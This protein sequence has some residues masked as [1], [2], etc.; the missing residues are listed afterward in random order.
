MFRSHAGSLSRRLSQAASGDLGP[1]PARP[2]KSNQDSARAAAQHPVG[3]PANET[4]LE[5]NARINSQRRSLGRLFRGPAAIRGQGGASSSWGDHELDEDDD[6]EYYGYYPAEQDVRRAGYPSQ[7][8][9]VP[10]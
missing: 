5:R 10:A 2:Q 7:H 3:S 9:A 1:V 8:G 4:S 6:C